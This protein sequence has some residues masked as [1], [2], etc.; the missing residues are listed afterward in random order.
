MLGNS[1]GAQCIEW[2][3]VTWFP[4]GSGRVHLSPPTLGYYE[5]PLQVCLIE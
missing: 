4:H 5:Q 1:Q 3:L 2:S